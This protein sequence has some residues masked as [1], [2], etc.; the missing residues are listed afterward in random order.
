MGGGRLQLIAKGE[1]DL[2]LIGN[3]IISF[4]KSV[5]RQYTNFSMETIENELVNNISKSEV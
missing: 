4:F 5:Y 1:E 2:Y 3:P